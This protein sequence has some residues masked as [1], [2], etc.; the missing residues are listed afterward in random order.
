MPICLEKANIRTFA[1]D[2]TLF[3]SS[4]S[5]QDLEKTI[6]EEFNHLLNYC[7]ADKLSVNFEK[8]HYIYDNLNLLSSKELHQIPRYLH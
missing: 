7:S 8:T 6:N 3:Y 5:L 2:N 4:N 1:D